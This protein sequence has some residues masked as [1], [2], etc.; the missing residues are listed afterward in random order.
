[1]QVPVVTR[2]NSKYDAIRKTIAFGIDKLNTLIGR[3]KKECNAKHLKTLTDADMAVLNE[4]LKVFQPIAAALDRLQGEK[5]ASQGYIMPSIISMK[6]KI[7][8]LQG[9]NLLKAF[10]RTALEV[11]NKRFCRYFDFNETT[12]DLIVAAVSNPKF[13]T[14]FIENCIH[15]Q[16]AIKMLSEECLNRFDRSSNAANNNANLN[17]NV[18]SEDD[19]FISFA[20]VSSQRRNSIENS[21][22]SEVSRYIADD[23]KEIEMLNDYPLVKKTYLKFNTTLSAS[24]PIERVFSQSKLLFRPQRNRLSAG[25]FERALLL[26]I[27]ESLVD[28]KKNERNINK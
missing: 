14:N 16:K 1:M 27:N 19:F 22:D 8:S 11:M 9:G 17:T 3:L 28:F 13:K 4:Y 15:Q 10:K 23:R 12:Y 2:W 25:N 20:S 24:A 7:A 5:T 18:Q 26:G 21:I 6:Y